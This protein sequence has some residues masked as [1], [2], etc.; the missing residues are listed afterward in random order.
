[1]EGAVLISMGTESG[2]TGAYFAVPPP[3]EQCAMCNPCVQ[4]IGVKELQVCAD[5]VLLGVGT[6]LV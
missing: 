6:F 5:H 2:S 1:M 3:P 4:V